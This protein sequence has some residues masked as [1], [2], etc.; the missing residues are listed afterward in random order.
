M[1]Q[2][3]D[4]WSMTATHLVAQPCCL[5]LRYHI[6]ISR[7]TMFAEQAAF[8]GLFCPHSTSP[9]VVEIYTATHVT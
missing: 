6:K 3:R 7:W 4:P 1:G 8:D 9:L 5:S 2:S